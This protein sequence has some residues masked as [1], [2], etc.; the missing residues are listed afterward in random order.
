MI[1][2]GNAGN[3]STITYVWA[4]SGEGLHLK[5][6]VGYS[7]TKRNQI[8]VR[9]FGFQSLGMIAAVAIPQLLL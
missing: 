8:S 3:H 4:G 5:T 1:A 7:M 2:E 9:L 6:S